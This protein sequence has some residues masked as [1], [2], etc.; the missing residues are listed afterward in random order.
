MNY[1]ECLRFLEK[2]QNLGIKFGLDNV[3]DILSFFDNPHQKYPS[4][5]VAGTNGKGSVC[6]MLDRILSL[7]NIRVGLYTSPH[8][9]K[10]E[11][12]IRINGEPISSRNFSRELTVLKDRIEALIASKRLLSFPTYFEFLTCLAFIY[13]G[14]QKIDIAILEVG[15]GGR[16]DATN[17]VGPLVSV[18]TT[19]SREHQKFLGNT[20]SQIAS[21]KA[22]IVKPG[23]PLVCGV[24]RGEAQRT[25]KKK[26]REL[27]ASFYGVFDR[28]DCF[29]A[30]KTGEGR[31]SFV[32]KSKRD[33]YSFTPSL[34]GKHQGKN[35]AVA[36]A[37]SEELEG[38]WR[39]LEKE[40]IIQ[41]IEETRWEGRLEVLSRS[42]L[43]ILDGAHNEEGAKALRDYIQEFV[44]NPFTLVVA[45]MRDKKITRMATLLFPLAERIILTR[46]PYFRAA[47]PEEISAQ[48]PQ[49]KEKFVLEAETEKAVKAAFS[50]ASP[51]GCVV[52]AGSLYLAGE[53]KK[54]FK[55]EGL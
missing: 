25:I 12:R 14:K 23:I 2:I 22:G 9:V 47:E 19:I 27:A 44:P 8:M 36:I 3:K 7:H 33:E 35:A 54:I 11:E 52:I 5:L 51:Q 45:F 4:V 13:F 53:V 20:L 43:V 48:A 40:K 46:F 1:H 37:T 42:P 18:I 17:V 39:K 34:L 10:V 31:Y 21:E 16:F 28:K 55:G 26:A 30:R 6:A 24:K 50:E 15:M 32:Y 29:Q 38:N 49:F 41:G